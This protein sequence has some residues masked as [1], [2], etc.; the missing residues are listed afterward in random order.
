MLPAFLFMPTIFS[1]VI[2][3]LGL[4]SFPCPSFAEVS[5]EKLTDSEIV[6]VQAAIAKLEPLMHERSMRKDLA[7]LTFD[8]LYAPL[9]SE[10]KEFFESIRTLDPKK[11]GIQTRWQALALGTEE[12]RILEGQKIKMNGSD[13]T[14]PPQFVPPHVYDAYERMM[15]AMEVDLGKRLYIESAYRSSAYQL[16]LFIF[17]LKN[18]EYSIRETAHWVALPGYSEHGNAEKQALDFISADGISGE[19][20][21]E[22]FA[23]LPEYDWLLREASKYGFI[24]SFPK[25]NAEGIGFEPW[26]WRFDPEAVPQ[27]PEK[28]ND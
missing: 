7:K 22:A 5:V 1:F 21:P 24:L 23:V 15:E 19:T 2:I 20:D 12:L 13:F 3:T 4:F 17:Y 28:T 8:E 27:T 6:L 11:N 10:E 25:T 26:H 16:Y 18:H 9:N 14:L